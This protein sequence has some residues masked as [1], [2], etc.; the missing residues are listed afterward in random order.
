[1]EKYVVSP[2]FDSLLSLEWGESLGAD[3][4][5]SSLG[6]H[7]WWKFP[8]YNGTRSPASRAIDKATE[9]GMVVVMAIGNYAAQR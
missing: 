8:D 7:R 3:L 5:S 6:Y 9:R 4:A 2:S 1:M